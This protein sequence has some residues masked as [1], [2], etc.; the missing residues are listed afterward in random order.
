LVPQPLGP[1]L[2]QRRSEVYPDDLSDASGNRLSG[3]SGTAGHIKEDH[4]SVQRFDP[5]QGPGGSAGKRRVRSREQGSLSLEGSSHDVAVITIFHRDIV[6]DW[7]NI[8][9]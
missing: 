4:V 8:G 2:E 7:S 5:G 3:V 1:D 6:P 9:Q